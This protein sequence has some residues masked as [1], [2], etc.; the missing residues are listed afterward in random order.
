MDDAEISRCRIAGVVATVISLVAM[1]V[2]PILAAF[3]IDF[4]SFGPLCL[5]IAIVAVFIPYTAWRNMQRLRAALETSSLGLLMTLPVLVFSYAAMRMALPITDGLLIAADRAIGF[6]WPGFVRWVD[7]YP[8]FAVALAYGYS[9]FSFQLLVLPILLA[10]LG[11]EGRA[12]QLVLGYLLLCSA[13][14][15]ISTFFPSLGAY[16]GYGVDGRALA[17]VNTHF[18]YFFLNSFAAVR[19]DPHF[20]LSLHNAAGIITFPSIHAGVALLCGWA[21]WT[22]RL[23]RLPFVALNLLMTVSAVTHGGHYLVDI[24]AGFA[25]A[26]AAIVTVLRLTRAKLAPMLAPPIVGTA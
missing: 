10:L 22:L 11:F 7:H 21:A 3:R 9:S 12:Y 18:G 15:S 24:F 19:D 23:L 1:F 6:D 2:A 25:V 17:H 5:L 8:R 26:A 4:A 20:T 14:I 13:A 16:Q